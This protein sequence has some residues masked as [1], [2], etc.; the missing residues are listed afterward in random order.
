MIQATASKSPASSA[1]SSHHPAIVVGSGFGGAVAADR[2]TAAGVRTL[3]LERGRDWMTPSNRSVAPHGYDLASP[4]WVWDPDTAG[5]TGFMAM[6]RAHYGGGSHVTLTGV[7]L[8]GGSLAYA[9]ATVRPPRK[10]FS[11]VLGGV[12]GHAEMEPVFDLVTRRIGA[13]PVPA[14]VFAGPA[15]AHARVFEDQLRRAGFPVSRIPAAF[16][17]D[18]VRDEVAG[19]RAPGLTGGDLLVLNGGKRS[20]QFNYLQRARRSGRL[21]VV[22]RHE[23]VGIWTDRGRYVVEASVI[24]DSRRT[25]RVVRFTCDRLF[26]GAGAAV[27]PGLILGSQRSGGLPNCNE[28]CGTL[29]GDN[30]D[31]VVARPAPRSDLPTSAP[32]LF[33]SAFVDDESDQLPTLVEGFSVPLAPGLEPLLV[34]FTMTADFENRTTWRFRDGRPELTI[35]AAMTSG[36]RAAARRI[37]QRMGGG[38]SAD[39]AGT[40]LASLL[41]STAH[42]LGGMPLG[43]ATDA[44]GQ[45]IGHRGLYV[46]D[47]SLIHGSAGGANPSLLIA[48]V[49]EKCMD[50]A[51]G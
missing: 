7:G 25:G 27:T 5:R 33:S 47:G 11:S 44:S 51:I 39:L 13:A 29:V 9:G 22:T 31:Q 17:W 10:Y 34:Q 28:H 4:G 23:V 38:P 45:V 24:G 14:D 46:V 16:N 2:L 35:P 37:H 6:D 8:G 15:F 43:R 32:G 40:P 1:P 21:T 42:L 50:A 48:A 12:L 30:G 3:L 49:A 41:N 18:I 26:L 19:R 36:A 20:L